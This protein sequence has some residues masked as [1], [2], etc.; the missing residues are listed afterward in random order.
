MRSFWTPKKSGGWKL[1]NQTESARRFFREV[2]FSNAR[3]IQR[4]LFGASPTSDNAIRTQSKHTRNEDAPPRY[5]PVNTLACGLE[6]RRGP[7][8]ALEQRSGRLPAQRHQ[9][10]HGDCTGEHGAIRLDQSNGTRRTSCQ[11][12]RPLTL[13]WLERNTSPRPLPPCVHGLRAEPT[14]IVV[15][16]DWQ[17]LLGFHCKKITADRGG[18]QRGIVRV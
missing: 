4:I 18:Q 14:G 6:N 10:K 7:V 5:D 1:G 9:S 12:T 15:E 2:P 17:R 16:H 11:T 8:K 3:V 13:G